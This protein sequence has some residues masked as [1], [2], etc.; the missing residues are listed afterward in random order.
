MS[1]PYTLEVD[2]GRCVAAFGDWRDP[3]LKH[4][5]DLRRYDSLLLRRRPQVIVEVG[6]YNGASARWFREYAPVISVDTVPP[7]AGDWR[8]ITCLTGDSVSEAVIGQVWDAVDGR[9]AM[10][11]LDSDHSTMHVLR[12]IIL[13]GPMVGDGCHLVVEDTILAWLPQHV[14][15]RHTCRYDGNPMEAVYQAH[16]LG[17]LRTFVRDTSVEVFDG[18]PT[19]HPAGWWLA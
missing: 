17:H 14:L 8:D 6:R 9:N 18:S 1:G 15:D 4:R 12:E 5:D 19:M 7:E 13:Y 10:I 2:K 3:M 11:V 16:G